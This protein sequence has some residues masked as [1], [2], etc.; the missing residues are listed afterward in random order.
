MAYENIIRSLG[1]DKPTDY[2]RQVRNYEVFN[3]L[4]KEG[5]DLQEI[6]DRAS[7]P[8]QPPMDEGLFSAMEDAVRDVLEV[9]SAGKLRKEAVKCIIMRL[10]A[11]DPAYQKAN[12]EYRDAVIKAYTE[13]KGESRGEMTKD[14]GRE[15]EER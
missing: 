15:P 14:P 7:N 5:A 11:D 3:R 9:K 13:R 8:P 10:C 6:V 1:L 2:D 4:M 12:K